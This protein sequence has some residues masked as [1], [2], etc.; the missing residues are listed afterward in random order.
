MVNKVLQADVEN[1]QTNGFSAAALVNDTKRAINEIIEQ[2]GT[3]SIIP[4]VQGGTGASTAAEAR[5]NLGA[6]KDELATPSV[7]GLMSTADKVRLESTLLHSTNKA[8]AAVVFTDNAFYGTAVAP[9]TA[10]ITHDIASAKPG[11]EISIYH[12]H[13]V[14]PTY[15]A[16]WV[17]LGSGTYATSVLN[18]IIA[19][20][21]SSTR[22][23]YVITQEA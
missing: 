21:V 15:P 14:A 5:T 7:K 6:A 17:L 2:G 12:N 23:E 9:I 16:E 18:T 22:I 3:G 19:R 8:G 20:Y 1:L 13:S 10:N 11:V 4:V